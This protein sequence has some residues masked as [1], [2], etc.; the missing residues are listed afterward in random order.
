MKKN[1]D[2]ILQQTLIDLEDS[3]CFYYPSYCKF[4]FGHYHRDNVFN[5]LLRGVIGSIFGH[6]NDKDKNAPNLMDIIKSSEKLSS[7]I[8]NRYFNG[9]EMSEIRCSVKQVWL[10]LYNLCQNDIDNTSSSGVDKIILRIAAVLTSI[11]R[12]DHKQLCQFSFVKK[13]SKNLMN[14]IHESVFLSIILVIGLFE[15]IWI[16]SMSPFKN[17]KLKNVCQIIKYFQFCCMDN[18]N[19]NE[20]NGYFLV[21]TERAMTILSTI[22]VNHFSNKN[23]S[24]VSV[25]YIL[26]QCKENDKLKC[27]L[28]NLNFNYFNLNAID[29]DL[30]NIKNDNFG[31]S[32]IHM[33]VVCLQC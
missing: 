31:L 16:E 8:I 22:R 21:G 11:I 28:T 10:T 5:W 6:Q 26:N 7:C 15:H 14:E 12:R 29:G 33:H 4:E 2:N 9:I 30:N 17:D 20:K 23:Q 19:N 3:L 24:G 32:P 18:I 27:I 25:G 1:E 13:M